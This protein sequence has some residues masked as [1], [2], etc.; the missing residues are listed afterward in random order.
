[1]TTRCANGIPAPRTQLTCIPQAGASTHGP[2]YGTKT[3][4]TQLRYRGD[5]AVP[6]NAVRLPKTR[7]HTA[8][9]ADPVDRRVS[10]VTALPGVTAVADFVDPISA[11]IRL[12]SITGARQR[13]TGLA[14]NGPNWPRPPGSTAQSRPSGHSCR[15]AVAERNSRLTIEID[16]A[17]LAHL[18]R[19]HDDTDDG[20]ASDQTMRS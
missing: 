5:P 15:H 20:Q 8:R 2:L 12:D 7:A 10:T 4:P 11:A 9:N 1:M 16:G 17:D 6:T 13:S 14:S 19:C 18:E 3:S